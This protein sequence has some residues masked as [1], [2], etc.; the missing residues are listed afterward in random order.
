MFM[1][2]SKHESA[3]L[4]CSVMSNV[5]LFATPWTAAHQAP[6]AKRIL[7]A[8][9]LEVGCHA[10]LQG[11][12]TTQGSNAGPPHCRQILYP[13][14]PPGKPKNTGVGSISL[15]QGNFPTQESNRGLLDCRQILYQLSYSGSP[16]MSLTCCN[17]D[18]VN[19]EFTCLASDRADTEQTTLISNTRNQSYLQKLRPF[20]L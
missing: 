17:L 5:Q 3:V 6:L 15:I 13:S 18:T 12:F 11:I 2:C 1:E 8:R 16:N 10:L 9:K 19:T 20:S 7:Q 14:E 4:S